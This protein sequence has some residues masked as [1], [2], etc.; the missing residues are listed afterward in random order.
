[1]PV[2]VL[3][4]TGTLISCMANQSFNTLPI[5]PKLIPCDRSIVGMVG[6]KLRPV[7]KCFVKLQIGK[8]VFRDRVVVIE[9]LR[10]KYILGQVLHRSYQFSTGYSTTGKHYI[11][12]N[13][14]VIAQSISQ[15]LDYLI[16]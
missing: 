2:N 8:G 15:A 10:C 14:Q 7:G 3:Y 4:D 11:T 5:K 13:G 1:M 9:N 12:I 16:I 6:E